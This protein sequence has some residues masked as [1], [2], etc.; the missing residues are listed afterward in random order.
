MGRS[1]VFVAGCLLTALPLLQGC[2]SDDATQSSSGA[3]D[4][5][6][7]QR[8]SASAPDGP[9]VVLAVNKLFLG[10][11][12]RNDKKVVGS[13]KQFGYN[14]DGKVSTIASKDLCKPA[15]GATPADV[16]LDGNNGIDNSFGKLLVPQIANIA[17]E[18]SSQVNSAIADGDFTIMLSLEKLGQKPSYSPLTARLYAG[19][20]LGAAPKWDG[21][22]KWPV[23][24]ELLENDMDIT[25][26]KVVFDQSYVVDN[27]WVSGTKGTVQLSI[28]ISGNPVNLT[29]SSAVVTMDLDAQ[30]TG[31][32]NGTISGVIETEVLV[33]EL[34]KIIGALQPSF[35]SGSAVDTILQL[36]RR[37]SDIM[38]DGTQD[39]T[40]ECD[41]ISIGLGFTAKQVQL[42]DIA[43]RTPPS[44]D[45]CE[46][47]G[48]AGGAGGGGGAGGSGGADGGGGAGGS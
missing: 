28:V 9:G 47:G 39:P 27:T 10:D 33:A 46:G 35:C 22:D 6:P 23:V 34:Q 12:D 40:K 7:P 30:R 4:G 42:G 38:K 21:T 16:Y 48:G 11:T 45:P 41:G 8:P 44:G 18:P 17:S 14:V 2:G 31:A 43:A 15:S 20:K 25:S 1:F 3:E 36:I 19:A 26:A 29:I 37:A 24:P 32:V 5:Q 13:W